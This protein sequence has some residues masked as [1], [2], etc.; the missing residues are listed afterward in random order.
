MKTQNGMN[1]AY[2][3]DVISAKNFNVKQVFFLMFFAVLPQQQ[4]LNGTN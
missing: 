4:R 1:T 2:N 3:D